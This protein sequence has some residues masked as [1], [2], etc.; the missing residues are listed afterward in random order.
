[1]P[2]LLDELSGFEFEDVMVDVFRKLGYESVRRSRRTGDEGRD[3]LME[4]VVDGV[5][6]GVV[7]ECKH[8][9]T[10]GRPVV[11][12]LHSA[13]A[14]Y[15]Y[16]GPTRGIVVTTGRFTDPARDY[17]A[18]VSESG[19]TPVDLIDGA[20][21]RDI[22]EEVGLDLYNGRIEILCDETLRPYDPASGV[23]AP[24]REAFTDVENVEADALPT[25]TARVTFQP[26]V[27]VVADVDATFETS[28]GVIHR[29]DVRDQFL[30]HAAPEGA[31][32]PGDDIQT[33][34]LGNFSRTTT[35][36]EDRFAAEFDDVDVV[37]FGA[38]ETDYKEWAVDRIRDA[39]TTTV[40]YTGDNNVDYEKECTPRESDVAVQSLTPVY[41]PQVRQTLAVE[42]YR[43]SL[44]YYNA[45]PSRL[46][47]DDGVHRCV[48][49]GET[50]AGTYTFCENCGSV[51]CPAHTKTER[52]V[53]EPVCTGC[54][55]TG[56]FMLSTK[57]FY[58]EANREA[59]RDQYEEM[60]VYEKLGENV[61]LVAGVVLGLL[62]LLAG[63]LV[64]AGVV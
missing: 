41:L 29:V 17:A 9:D 56:R 62:A 24:M 34:V 42:S 8:Q 5:R 20:A 43:Y 23:H 45:G 44:E 39:H 19:E 50:D 52:L 15:D 3:V 63:T 18:R 35:L 36:E 54:A 4:E 27:R 47:I 30:V 14:T 16:D 33:L 25:P 13:A 32:V 10:V 40:H 21:L 26:L 28:V 64:A 53:G 31:S 11:Q 58:D 12:K 7:V 1:M 51:N 6:R 59:F 49:C 37:R 2:A 46:T 38:T 22:A 55:V 60:A 57:Y 48:Q 61:P